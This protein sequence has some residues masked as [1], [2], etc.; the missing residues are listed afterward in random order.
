[1]YHQKK[2]RRPA[3]ITVDLLTFAVLVYILLFAACSNF[4]QV[5]SRDDNGFWTNGH[6]ILM[7]GD[8]SYGDTYKEGAKINNKYGYDY[9]FSKVASFLNAVDYS[10]INLETPI[11][12][13]DI[14][15][16]RN[17]KRWVHR[18]DPAIYPEYMQKC[19]INAVSLA[20]NHSMDCGAEGLLETI[21][22]LNSNDISHIGA[23]SN[24]DEAATP[25]IK[26]II[27]GE[28]H[29]KLAVFAAYENR[30]QGN[31]SDLPS[32]FASSDRPGVNLLA[33][34]KIAGLIKEFK[35]NNPDSFIVAFP[36][37]GSNYAWKSKNQTDL[38]EKLIDA[39]ADIIIGHGA[40][41]I[42]EI[43]RYK[44]KWIIYSLGN[45]VFN[46]PGRY[47]DKGA[48]P[49]SAISILRFSLENNK[50]NVSFRLYP[51]MTDNLLTN[52]QTRPVDEK[53]FNKL[54]E[55]LKNK[56]SAPDNPFSNLIKEKD[57]FGFYLEGTALP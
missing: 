44:D 27:I 34:E 41:M 21:K 11:T 35:K 47:Q 57:K 43:E 8:F 39:G 29:I 13:V 31:R 7:G 26:D 38:A 2:E 25:L 20:N 1:M 12:S 22:I 10:I 54:I 24:A 4:V 53:E 56:Q 55:A 23:E 50:F 14:G 36:H 52:Y 49:Y 5:Q 45:F 37:W 48:W 6:K 42:Q 51:T 40:H 30:Y 28:K 3:K 32:S 33:P 15:P 17:F 19:R 18:G 16:Y 9:S 46:S